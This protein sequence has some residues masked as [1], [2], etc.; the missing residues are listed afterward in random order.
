MHEIGLCEGVLEAVRR[1]ADGRPVAG[2]RVR[3][4]VRHAVVPAAME[5]AFQ[6]VAG[7]TEADGA[8]VDVVQVPVHLRC[9]A[10]GHETDTLDV[11]AVCPR[12]LADTV[13]VSGGDEL[14]LESIQYVP[15]P[16]ER[17]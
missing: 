8:T 4:G 13:V 10:C 1:R 12:C 9:E 17:A 6:L 15:E 16:V 11:L 2:I 5:Q 7:G 3:A 14:T